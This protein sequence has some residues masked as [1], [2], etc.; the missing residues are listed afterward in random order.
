ML[1]GSLPGLSLPRRT[2]LGESTARQET[3]CS[4]RISARSLFIVRRCTD[5]SSL[6]AGWHGQAAG[7]SAGGVVRDSVYGAGASWSAGTPPGAGSACS[8]RRCEAHVGWAGGSPVD[9]VEVPR[10]QEGQ[11]SQRQRAPRRLAVTAQVRGSDSQRQAQVVHHHLLRLRAGWTGRK[12]DQMECTGG[13]SVAAS[14]RLSITICC[15]CGR[16][17]MR[18]KVWGGESSV[19]TSEPA[20]LL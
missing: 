4:A 3:H 1:P 11:R 14:P 2:S 16:V 8:R 19:E 20:P 15:A 5:R 17:E 13:P 18:W 6:R 12:G 10:R 9:G 7:G